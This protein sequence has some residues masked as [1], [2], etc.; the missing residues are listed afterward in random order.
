M[1]HP[2]LNAQRGYSTISRS[3]AFGCLYHLKIG[4]GLLFF[5]RMIWFFRNQIWRWNICDQTGCHEKQCK[6]IS[7][8]WGSPLPRFHCQRV[9]KLQPEIGSRYC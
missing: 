5:P 3:V 1:L 8:E 7:E 4:G 2:K 6:K 9:L